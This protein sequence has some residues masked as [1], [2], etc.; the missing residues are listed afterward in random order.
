MKKFTVGCLVL[1]SLIPFGSNSKTLN[2]VAEC[3]A[4]TFFY[5]VALSNRLNGV[6]D[7]DTNTKLLTVF[8]NRHIVGLITMSAYSTKLNNGLIDKSDTLL[9]HRGGFYLNCMSRF[10]HPAMRYS[11]T[12]Q[13]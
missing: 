8:N 6:S 1:T 10:N 11:Y 13:A 9:K 12:G 4:A 7:Q 3:K 5:G 2:P